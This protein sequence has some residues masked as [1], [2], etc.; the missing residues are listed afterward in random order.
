MVGSAKQKFQVHEDLISERSEFF[1]A[2]VSKGWQE[3]ESRTVNLPKQELAAFKIYLESIYA[4]DVD[5][6]AMTKR[7]V[8]ELVNQG[9]KDDRSENKERSKISIGH[10]KLWILGDFL[11]DVWFKNHVMKSMVQ[12]YN[13]NKIM[14]LPDESW[15]LSFNE[16]T[17][18]SGL[19]NFFADRVA[20]LI[21]T[22]DH[23]DGLL[24]EAPPACLPVFFKAVLAQKNSGKGPKKW[25][26]NKYLEDQ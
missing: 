4:H 12:A 18:G 10:G 23:V 16:T 1:K 24:E 14:L 15:D 25:D 6:F 17:V 20:D 22:P 7:H 21:K 13:D 11:G 8:G 2:A 9:D 26:V 3:A 5:L 19:Q